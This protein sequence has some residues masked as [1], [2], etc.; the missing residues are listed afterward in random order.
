MLATAVMLMPRPMLRQIY[1]PRAGAARAI[2]AGDRSVSWRLRVWYS[3][4]LLHTTWYPRIMHILGRVVVGKIR[5]T[6]CNLPIALEIKSKR[7]IV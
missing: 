5:H 1:Q 2:K 4:D 7:C 6:F 3:G